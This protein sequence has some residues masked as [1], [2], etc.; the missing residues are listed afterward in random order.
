MTSQ[1]GWA[2]WPSG[3][4]IHDIAAV[5]YKLL[6]FLYDVLIQLEEHCCSQVFLQLITWSGCQQSI[7]KGMGLELKHSSQIVT[8]ILVQNVIIHPAWE[9]L[10]ISLGRKFN[11]GEGS[12]PFSPVCG[13]AAMLLKFCCRLCML[14]VRIDVQSCGSTAFQSG[15]C[16]AAWL[17]PRLPRT[18]YVWTEHVGRALTDWCGTNASS[19]HDSQEAET[20]CIIN[21]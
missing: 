1:A 21:T 13:P 16:L 15:L 20:S 7:A 2:M 9:R 3:S 10:Q 14:Q 6:T 8:K 19:G 11:S 5:H 17:D 4:E 18:M 12:A